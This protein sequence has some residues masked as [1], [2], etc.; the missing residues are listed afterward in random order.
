MP[1]KLWHCHFTDGVD[2]YIAYGA[3]RDRM[4]VYDLPN[5]YRTKM[6]FP[7]CTRFM[8]DVDILDGPDRT[9]TADE[10]KERFGLV[11]RRVRYRQTRS[12]A[13]TGRLRGLGPR[14]R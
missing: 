14:R 8:Q 3:D 13:V 12:T 5:G 2:T 7:A 6:F 1:S 10:I 9:M 4:R 11:T